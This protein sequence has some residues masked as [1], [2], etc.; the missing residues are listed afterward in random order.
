MLSIIYLPLIFVPRDVL[1]KLVRIWLRG[2]VMLSA[3]VL[4]L[5]YEIRG[6]E[7]CACGPIIYASKHQSAWET[8]LFSLI[9][10][11]CAF[12]LKR[13][14]MWIPFWGWFVWRMGMVGID[15]TS[16]LKSIKAMIAGAQS[17]VASGRSIVV[18]PQGT[19]VAPGRVAPYHPGIAAI[20][21]QLNVSVVPVALNSGMFWPRRRLVKF[22]GMITVEFLKPIP[23]GLKKS[24]FMALLETQIEEA[25]NQLET[26]AQFSS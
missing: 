1:S 17:V 3:L 5:R 2:I 9:V 24:E 7:N 22:P 13:E 18:F 11:D 25:T 4:N 23:P 14:L 12:V 21:G 19:R 16:G 6:T 10:P 26:D 20:Y 15:R 8:L